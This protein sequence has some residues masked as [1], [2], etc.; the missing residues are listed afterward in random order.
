MFGHGTSRVRRSLNA[1]VRPNSHVTLHPTMNVCPSKARPRLAGLVEG[2]VPNVYGTAQ[3]LLAQAAT[4]CSLPDGQ[5]L[6]A[7][8]R[9]S[10]HDE[11]EFAT[12]SRRVRDSRK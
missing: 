5:V 4:P 11:P 1:C 8:V 3:A 7:A 9:T 10:G 12:V 6:A 2:E